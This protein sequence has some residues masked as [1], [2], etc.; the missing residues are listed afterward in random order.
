MYIHQISV[1]VENKA[2]NLAKLTNFLA[3]K[4]VNLRA[5]EVSDAGDYGIIRLIVDHPITT[6]TV[7]KD[8]NW[9]CNLTEVIGVKFPDEPGS[10]AKTVSLL[11]E[12]GIS[13]EYCY[14]FL[15]KKSND[16]LMIFR[17]KDNEKVATILKKNG[18]KIIAQEDLENI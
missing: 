4:N 5:L 16:A 14:A 13:V 10:M 8:N 17:V 12:E 9:V 3:D 18:I 11:A 2:G 1:F 15:A 7:L 6:L